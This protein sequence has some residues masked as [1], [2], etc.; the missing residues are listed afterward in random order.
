MNI[1]KI[2]KMKN[3]KYKIFIDD[4]V[5]ITYD[6]VILAND[7]LYKKSIDKKT[8]IKM[9]SDTNYY[10]VYNKVVNYI[11][12]RR[13][14]EKEIVLY[15]N[16]FSL[17][18]NE[19]NGIIEKLRDIKLIDDIEFCRAYINDK[20]YL[21]KDGIL[22]IKNDLLKQNIPLDIIEDALNNIDKNIIDDRLE[23]MIIKKIR[24]NNK[25]SNSY[26]KQKILNEMMNKGY[27]KEKILNIIDSNINNDNDILNKEFNKIY[28]NLSKK[29][30]GYDL[31]NNVKQ[32]LISKGFKIGD[33]NLL[34]DQKK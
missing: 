14:S 18:E 25:Y 26:L 24:T 34:L 6:N 17:G 7:L 5:L 1:N 31:E 23:K 22:K 19:K 8:Y 12:K 30:S 32:R 27:N 21:S 20:L 15:L 28:D 16:K 3:N 9:I 29:Y 33:I 13:R 4:E 11:L 2:V 10:D